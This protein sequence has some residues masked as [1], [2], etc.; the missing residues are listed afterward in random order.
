[1]ND[2]KS[3]F[4][5][6]ENFN[7]ENWLD[8][9]SNDLLVNI[10]DKYEIENNF[11]LLVLTAFF[12]KILKTRN[13]DTIYKKNYNSIKLNI[14]VENFV[15]ELNLKLDSKNLFIENSETGTKNILIFND[16]IIEISNSKNI[17]F[18]A[19]DT[20]D[21]FDSDDGNKEVSITVEKENSEYDVTILTTNKNILDVIKDFIDNALLAYKDLKKI[22]ILCETPND[23]ISFREIGNINTPLKK[24]N[25]SQDVIKKFNKIIK[26]LHSNT[27]N[28]R[29][30]IIDG[31]PGT[32]KTF[33]V[34]GILDAVPEN[35]TRVIV[36]AGLISH[37]IEPKNIISLVTIKNKTPGPL[38]FFL[39][40]ADSILVER[41][42]D[43]ISNISAVLNLGDGIIGKLLDIRIIA[44]T[45]AKKL[46][47]DKAILRPGRLSQHVSIERLDPEH[48]S[49]IYKSLTNKEIVFNKKVTLAEIYQ[50]AIQ[51]N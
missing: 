25:Y 20:F 35:S 32:G 17:K 29:L 45:N 50:T 39:E 11:S 15:K 10:R 3:D 4:Y 22:S 46:E 7:K 6:V 16:G 37:L 26:D 31:E 23:G 13:I 36:P 41:Q 5:D 47:I 27:P 28:G 51:E 21:T 34:R 33:F 43:N 30:T 49:N 38:I 44:T 9:I 19:F 18:Y 2:K 24:E 8:W 40:D 1:M 12:K 14:T 48:A 42:M